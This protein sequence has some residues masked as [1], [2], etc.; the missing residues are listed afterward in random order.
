MSENVLKAKV[1]SYNFK[2]TVRSSIR[3]VSAIFPCFYR[4]M[5]I[6]LDNQPKITIQ[7]CI[8]GK[9]GVYMDGRKEPT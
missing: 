8:F 2:Q 7:L 3:L 1:I 4:F 9:S 6:V 5:K